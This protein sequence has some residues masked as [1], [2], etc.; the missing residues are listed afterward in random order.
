MRKNHDSWQNT[1]YLD[2]ASSGTTIEIDKKWSRSAVQLS[3]LSR[4]RFAQKTY[5]TR[6]D[7]IFFY[8]Y[9]HSLVFIYFCFVRSLLADFSLAIF[10]SD[11]MAIVCAS[12]V[13][14]L[15]VLLLLYRQIKIKPIDEYERQQQQ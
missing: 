7:S 12:F 6:C 13:R 1:K 14:L 15:L 10:R 5:A 8:D 9:F 2:F 3:L 11:P 4:I